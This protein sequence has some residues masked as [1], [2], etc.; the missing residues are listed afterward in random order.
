MESQDFHSCPSVLRVPWN[1]FKTGVV[2]HADL[3]MTLVKGEVYTDCSLETGMAHHAGPH[4][5]A[6]ECIRRQKEQEKL[7]ARAFIVVYM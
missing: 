2:Q 3:E 1:F 5:G 6:A 4:K 7:W